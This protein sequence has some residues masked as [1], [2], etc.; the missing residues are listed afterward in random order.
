M[1]RC[2][3]EN[4]IKRSFVLQ[5]A[6]GGLVCGLVLASTIGFGSPKPAIP[7]LPMSLADC[8]EFGGGVNASLSHI[9]IQPDLG[10]Q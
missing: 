4:Q 7:E 3:L 6:I 10:T 1:T 2:L 8:T 9:L 5:G